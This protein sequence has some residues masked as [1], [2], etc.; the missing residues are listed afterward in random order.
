MIYFTHKQV[1]KNVNHIT[2]VCESALCTDIETNPGPV[3]YV[4]SLVKQSAHLVSQGNQY[5]FGETAGQQ[6][7]AMYLCA[8]IYSEKNNRTYAHHRTWSI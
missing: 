8:L 4:D 1:Y 3:F 6:C 7:L 5:I 2:N